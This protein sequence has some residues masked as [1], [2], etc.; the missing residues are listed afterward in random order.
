MVFKMQ[1]PLSVQAVG[2]NSYACPLLRGCW[3]GAGSWFPKILFVVQ[4][5]MGAEGILGHQDT[6]SWSWAIKFIESNTPTQGRGSK[7]Q[8]PKEAKAAP[9]G[10]RGRAGGPPA[11]AQWSQGTAGEGSGDHWWV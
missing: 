3:Q 10:V 11:K 7:A 9:T 4:T 8:D 1:M 2:L 6:S 5:N